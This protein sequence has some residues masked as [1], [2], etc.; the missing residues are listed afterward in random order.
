MDLSFST[1]CGTASTWPLDAM[2]QWAADHAFDCVRLATAGDIEPERILA[3]GPDRVKDTLARHG[4]YLAALQAGSSSG[5][6]LQ[7]DASA[8]ER[9]QQRLLRVIDV[10]AMLGAPVIVTNT[11]SPYSWHFYGMPSQPP[12]NA[13]D[14]SAEVVELF[15]EK[16][17][18]I[19]RHAEEKGVK[20]ALDTAVRMGNI[21]CVPEMWE[22]C[23]NAIPSDNLGL[24]CDPSHLLWLHVTPVEDALRMFPGKWY[25][26]DVKDCE[27]D[28]RMLFR[29]GIIGN[30]WWQYRVPGR[31]QLNWGTIIGALAE[32]GYDYVLCVENEDRGIPSLEGFDIG[33]RHLAQFLPGKDRWE[34]PRPP[35]YGSRE[36]RPEDR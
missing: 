21:A 1:S 6:V 3:E 16:F 7:A 9:N 15:R 31:G 4:L 18:P 34:G 14:H 28:R 23:L 11:G 32:C 13:T 30:W 19:V 2:A 17:T 10:A 33:R 5:A 12:G 24:S 8:I 26:A 29:Q 36:K 35:Q 20:I 25:Y 22:R 27:I